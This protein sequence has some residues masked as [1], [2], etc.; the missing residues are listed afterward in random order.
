MTS[1]EMNDGNDMASEG[2]SL[3]AEFAEENFVENDGVHEYSA[4]TSNEPVDGFSTVPEAEE[5]EDAT[6]AKAQSAIKETSTS[7]AWD[8]DWSPQRLANELQ[9][10]EDEIREV[11]DGRD[12]RRKRK[13]TGTRRWLELQEDLITMQFGDKFDQQTLA[14]IQQL[15]RR[16]HSLFS[17]LRYLAGTRP[18]WNT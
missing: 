18:T 1:D 3:G 5:V 8:R 9:H 10:I 13:F 6:R 4:P 7:L 12:P 2:D 11:L 17:Q 14:R 15:V 16:R